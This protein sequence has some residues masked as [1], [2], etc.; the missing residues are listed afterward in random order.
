MPER[1]LC[2][3]ARTASGSAGRRT[4]IRIVSHP[5]DSVSRCVSRASKEE[6]HIFAERN[7]RNK[8]RLLH[9]CYR[10][11]PLTLCNCHME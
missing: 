6:S 9:L 11:S 4:Q 8:P 2:A 3:S 5:W 1:Q 7:R 10:S